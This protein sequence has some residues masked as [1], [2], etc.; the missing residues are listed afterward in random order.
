MM[1]TYIFVVV[2]YNNYDDT[3]ELLESLKACTNCNFIIRCELI[4]NSENTEIV[5]KIKKLS[6]KFNFVNVHKTQ[7]NIGYFGAFN[8]FLKNY[9]TGNDETIILCNNDLT[10]NCDFCVQLYKN[11]YPEDVLAVCPDVVTFDGVHQNPHVAKPLG[12][13]SRS[14]LDLYYSTYW[15]ARLLTPFRKIKCIFNNNRDNG[16]LAP[17]YLF[18]GIGAC[19]VLLPRFFHYFKVLDY[20]YFLYG[21]EA[22]FSNQVHSVH[23][24]IYFDPALMVSHK[25]SGTLMHVPSQKK[26]EYARSGYWTYR[27]LY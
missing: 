4:D 27:K 8:Y 16:N 20:P 3:R 7:Q 26:Y 15:I 9:T 6:Q 23:K 10:F 12:L 18:M 21:E 19:Y 22:Y 13:L 24:Q 2:V 14:K 11:R 25:E 5:S 17:G 1:Q